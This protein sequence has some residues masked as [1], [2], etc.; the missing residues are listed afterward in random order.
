MTTPIYPLCFWPV[1]KDYIWG[2]DRI[3]RLYHRAEPPGRYAESW[4]ISDRADG[5]SVIRNGPLAGQTLADVIRDAG[6]ALLGTSVKDRRFP[7]LIKLIDS[8]DRL[9]VQVHP[10]DDSA[11]R[12]GGEA[13]TEMWYVLDA[14][15]GAGVFA[16]LRPGADEQVF[17][18]ALASRRF[19][20]LLT[21]VPVAP[22]DAVFVPGG[23]VHAI[24]AGCV[25]LEV[26][27]NSNTTYR[28]YDWD[29]VGADGKPRELHLQ[30]ALRVIRWK[31]SSVAK[32]PPRKLDAIGRNERWEIIRCAY[33]RMERIAV[34]AR[35]RLAGDERT[36]QALFVPKA[37]VTLHWNG[38]SLPLAPGTSC[39]VPAALQECFIE[40]SA[41][42]AE[43]LRV[44]VV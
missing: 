9:S 32:T 4:E 36:F 1:Y 6:P 8:R 13:K 23:R 20:D 7:L 18:D 29:R 30:E 44:T 35:C 5:M 15:A 43:V 10:D 31:E 14:D 24:D 37:G 3:I 16:G 21:F 2:G 38:E 28:I 34:K 22:G 11:K 19:K 27:Q 12:F 40:P 39:L 17:H 42:G 26:Q 25:L 41:E 33:F